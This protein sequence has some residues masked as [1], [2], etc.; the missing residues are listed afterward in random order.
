MQKIKV[1]AFKTQTYTIRSAKYIKKKM[2][3]K[4]MDKIMAPEKKYKFYYQK[5][6][7]ALL[8]KKCS[9]MP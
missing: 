6:T 9:L 7:L 4:L 1:S 5:I 2:P 3:C 8:D